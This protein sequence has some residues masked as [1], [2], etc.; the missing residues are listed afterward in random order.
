VMRLPLLDAGGTTIGRIEDLVLLPATGTTAPIVL[1]FVASSQRRRIFVNANRVADLGD[2]GARLRSWDVD[3]NPFKQ[4]PGELL[5]AKDLLDR[6][7]GLET[8]SDVALRRDEGSG[9]WELAKVRLARRTGL[10]RRPSYRLVDWD[11]LPEL[12]T[13]T[14]AAAE[15]ARLRDMHPSDVAAL[16]RNLPVDKRKQLADAMDDERLADLLEELPEAEQLRLI[17]EL[18]PDRLVDVLE[19]MEYDDAAD[20]LAE[21]SG[22]QRNQVLEAMDAND[23][24]VIRRLLSYGEGTAGGLMNP[25]VVILGPTATVAEALAHIRDPE[26]IATMA[27][28][29]FVTEPPFVPPTGRFL[30]VV[31]FQRLLREPPATE[32]RQCAEIEAVVLPDTP[33]REVAEKLAAYNLLALP[34]CDEAGRLLGAVTVDDVLDRAL[35]AGWRQR[36]RTGRNPW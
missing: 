29:V 18:D 2:D 17:A 5:V 8:V 28:Q 19:E 7:V 13:T 16:V 25:E 3:L 30:G 21:M 24:G 4:R 36:G 1:G 27:A 23:A 11:E 31:H 9:E 22:E 33:E 14:E 12:F 26:W 15:A 32:L 20:L 6:R 35:P 10:R 34:V